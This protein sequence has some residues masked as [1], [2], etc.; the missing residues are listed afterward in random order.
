M[1]NKKKSLKFWNENARN[2]SKMAYSDKKNYTL[3]PS[4]E[5]R[6]FEI[7]NYLRGKNKKSKILD[8]GCADG[9]L[10]EDLINIGFKN[11]S[12]ID[13]SENMISIAKKKLKNNNSKLNFYTQDVEKIKLKDE[14]NIITAIGLIEYLNNINKFSK[15][16]DNLLKKNGILIIESRNKLFNLYSSN[17][18]TLND[19][20]KLDK[21]FKEV[22][23]FEKEIK[24]KKLE[25]ITINV[26]KKINE[27]SK[28]H[29]KTNNKIIQKKVAQIPLSLPQ[30]TPKEIDK[31]FLKKNYKKIKNIFYH[32]HLFPPNY[33]KYMPQLYNKIGVIMQPYG[34]TSLGALICSSFLSIYKKL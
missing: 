33:S 31:I 4:S 21:Y 26:I 29:K 10:M 11:L 8:I 34:H 22:T 28:I 1:I 23:N 17:K 27:Y 14:Y 19:K 9:K 18:Y 3:F 20:N 30:Y 12:G 32:A 13:N 16:I 7:V 2:W 6:N 24:T 25:Q 15:N 5:I